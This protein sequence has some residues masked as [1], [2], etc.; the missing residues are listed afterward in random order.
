MI[1]KQNIAEFKK[2]NTDLGEDGYIQYIETRLNNR[3]LLLSNPELMRQLGLDRKS[4]VGEAK[5]LLNISDYIEIPEIIAKSELQR[6]EA[7]KQR[8]Q[9]FRNE[10]LDLWCQF[11]TFYIE[12]DGELPPEDIA[13]TTFA[14]YGEEFVKAQNDENI[15]SFARKGDSFSEFL[16]RRYE[17]QVL[18]DRAEAR[19]VAREQPEYDMPE[20]AG[21]GSAD[22]CDYEP[23]AGS[24]IRDSM[25]KIR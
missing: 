2:M 7:E 13:L 9:E 12:K 11:C 14:R 10:H 16:N 23:R 5:A 3:L 20:T 21:K 15:S 6:R 8:I 1:P 17:I 4:V 19:G 18:L 25:S 24:S 22:Y